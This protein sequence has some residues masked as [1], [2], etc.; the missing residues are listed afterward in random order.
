MVGI[1]ICPL[2]AYRSAV[3]SGALAMAWTALA[4]VVLFCESIRE[5]QKDTVDATQVDCCDDGD[6]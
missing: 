2:K 5:K 3:L 6:D 1:V 4:G